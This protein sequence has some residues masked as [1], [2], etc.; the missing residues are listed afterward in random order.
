MVKKYNKE[1]RIKPVQQ[2]LVAK[3]KII[4]YT[5]SIDLPRYF[6]QNIVYKG[7]FET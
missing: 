7:S 3:C 6:R 5:I 4:C 1:I 2:I